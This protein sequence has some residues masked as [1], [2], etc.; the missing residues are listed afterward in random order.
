MESVSLSTDEAIIEERVT[1]KDSMKARLRRCRQQRHLNNLWGHFEPFV[2]SSNRLVG[3]LERGLPSG[4]G[5]TLSPDFAKC[6]EFLLHAEALQT[7][8]KPVFGRDFM[9]GAVPIEWTCAHV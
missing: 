6:P 1:I 9:V 2:C 7:R 8:M 5:H 4:K 3:G